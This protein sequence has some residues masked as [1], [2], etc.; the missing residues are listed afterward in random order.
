MKMLK[1]IKTIHFRRIREGRTNYKKRLNIL[2]S[3]KPR[4]VV[5]KSLKNISAQ[6]TDY[7]EDG[8]LIKVSASSRELKKLGW[9][10][11][12]GNIPASYLV[13][14]LLGKK[15]VK[16]KIKRAILD[17]GLHPS[18]KGSRI[19]AVV[20][21]ALDSGLNIPVG[22][23]MLPSNDDVKGTRI[24][25]HALMLSKD[26]DNYSKYFSDYLENDLV[27]EDL[28]KHFDEIKSVIEKSYKSE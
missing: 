2:I 26:K 6:L 5:R 13:G 11:N 12:Y 15:A 22:S 27:P 20:K 4:L 25:N 1:L 23:E 28:P 8:D 21:G 24:S 16:K 14:Y 17:I 18:T 7:N 3:N 10:A 9:K 19:Y